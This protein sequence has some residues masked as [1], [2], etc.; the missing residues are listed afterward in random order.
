MAGFTLEY[1]TV[2][3]F[4]GLGA[5]GI[6]EMLVIAVVAVIL[7]GGRLPQVARSLGSSY[8]QFRKGLSDIQS[9]IKN[10]LD[11]EAASLNHV[12]DYSDVN[13]DYDE[14]TAP[15]FEPPVAEDVDEPVG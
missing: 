6:G 7:F 14:P 2:I 3:G 12:T 8:Q 15:K 13:D 4:F 5:P 1:F 10:D 9:S 11:I